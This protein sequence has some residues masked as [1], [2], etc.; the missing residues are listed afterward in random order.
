M[1]MFLSAFLFDWLRENYSLLGKFENQL[2]F[3]SR[4]EPKRND[5]RV[6]KKRVER[7]TYYYWKYAKKDGIIYLDTTKLLIE[8]RK[9]NPCCNL[10]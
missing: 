5:G 10:R 7:A 1:T 6:R 8:D 4:N 3:I 9:G 2:V